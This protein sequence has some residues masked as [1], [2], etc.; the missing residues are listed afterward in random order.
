MQDTREASKYPVA[1]R[2]SK[3]G[4][5]ATDAAAKRRRVSRSQYIRS[6]VISHALRELEGTSPPPDNSAQLQEA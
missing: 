2:F 3:S 4:L 1:V 5:A 6:V